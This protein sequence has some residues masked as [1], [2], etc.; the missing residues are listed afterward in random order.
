[1]SE[2]VRAASAQRIAA[3]AAK[4]NIAEVAVILHGGEPLLAGAG[5]LAEIACSIRAAMPAGTTARISMQTNGTLLTQAALGTLAEAGIRIGVSLD[6]TDATNDA[7]RRYA[8]GRGSAG[9]IRAGLALLGSDRYRPLF[10][11]LLCVI[12]SDTDPVAGYEA[13]L[14]HRPPLMDFLLPHANWVTP[15]IPGRHGDWLIKLF[16]RW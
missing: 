12:D 2:A 10:A 15:P 16:Q 13:L 14:E 4:H 6:G 5:T 11:G 1:M 7:H 8:H 3:H 9:R